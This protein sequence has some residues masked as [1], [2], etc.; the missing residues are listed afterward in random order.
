LSAQGVL[1]GNLD[2]ELEKVLQ[3]N[4]RAT[5]AALVDMYK[6]YPAT[7]TYSKDTDKDNVHTRMVRLFDVACSEGRITSEERDKLE[8]AIRDLSPEETYIL[9]HKN[10]FDPMTPKEQVT[11]W[12]A[13]DWSD[14][15]ALSICCGFFIFVLLLASFLSGEPGLPIIRAVCLPLAFCFFLPILPAMFSASF[16]SPSQSLSG[17]DF[18]WNVKNV[19][20]LRQKTVARLHQWRVA[21]AITLPILAV[22]A[23]AIFIWGVL[24]AL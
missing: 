2:E 24:P 21:W 14:A 4:S 10:G 6:E 15:G 23:G 11:D 12:R 8:D 5:L 20:E 3:C 22:I 1:E 7:V 9:V 17:A 16:Q 19:R 13:L 18:R